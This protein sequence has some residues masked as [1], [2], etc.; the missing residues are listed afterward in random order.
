MDIR[1]LSAALLSFFLFLAALAVAFRMT[2]QEAAIVWMIRIFVGI[3]R[4]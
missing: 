4:V 2:R 1:I 3:G